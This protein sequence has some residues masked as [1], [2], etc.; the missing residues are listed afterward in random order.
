MSSSH[1]LSHTHLQNMDESAQ[2]IHHTIE[3]ISSEMIITD[4]TQIVSNSS[5]YELDSASTSAAD[6]VNDLTHVMSHISHQHNDDLMTSSQQYMDNGL[7][8]QH[9]SSQIIAQVDQQHH[10]QVLDSSMSPSQSLAPQSY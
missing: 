7:G 1:T 3:D 6:H 10:H 9:D 8:E 5:H 4:H 2:Q